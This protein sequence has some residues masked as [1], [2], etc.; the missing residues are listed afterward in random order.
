[1][2]RLSV[3]LAMLLVTAAASPPPGPPGLH[4]GLRPIC[5]GGVTIR[6]AVPSAAD[7]HEIVV[8]LTRP[9]PPCFVAN[10]PQLAVAG[11]KPFPAG[12]LSVAAPVLL[13][14]G[15]SAAFA[16]RTVTQNAAPTSPS[17]EPA[18]TAA[19]VCELELLVNG[20]VA[21]GRIT[22][23]QPCAALTEL[24]VSSYASGTVPPPEAA[25]SASPASVKLAC[26]PQDLA[27]RD[28]GPDAAPEG[29]RERYALQNVGLGPCRIGS[30]LDA[31]LRDAAGAPIPLVVAP[32]TMMAMLLALPRGHEASFALAYPSGAPNGEQR[33]VTADSIAVTLPGAG[34]PLLA[35]TRLS[36]CPPAA[37]PGLRISNLQLGV[38]LPAART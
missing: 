33:C 13:G 17:P 23:P 11:A 21:R 15:K 4:G 2:A 6:S 10:Y 12:R 19:A 35:P 22:L 26:R 31:G 20:L 36:V 34:S 25:A 32:R 1:M 8:V 30:L 29:T 5:I 14:T 28:A 24:D 9:G 27:V 7:A 3:L 38:P 37:G 18:P 16:I